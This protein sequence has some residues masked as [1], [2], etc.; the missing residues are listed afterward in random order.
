MIFPRGP[1]FSDKAFVRMPSP[2]P[3]SKTV[4]P[5]MGVADAILSTASR[6]HKKTWLN[7]ADGGKSDAFVSPFSPAFLLLFGRQG[8]FHEQVVFLPALQL[9]KNALHENLERAAQMRHSLVDVVEAFERLFL[10]LVEHGL[11][12]LFADARQVLDGVRADVYRARVVDESHEFLF[13]RFD[14]F[15]DHLVQLPLRR[16]RQISVQDAPADSLYLVALLAPDV[17]ALFN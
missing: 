10:A 14:G 9:C 7:L 17:N 1:A 11:Q 5:R 16:A 8:F 13:A 3:I 12:M 2:A 6:S 4:F 15:T